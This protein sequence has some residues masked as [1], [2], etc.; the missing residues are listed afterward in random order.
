MKEK[1]E[2]VNEREELN[3]RIGELTDE[4]RLLESRTATVES[5]LGTNETPA[6]TPEVQ[7]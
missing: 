4:L 2:R 1:G 7:Q 3:K 5:K 6:V